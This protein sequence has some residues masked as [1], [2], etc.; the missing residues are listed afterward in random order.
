MNINEFMNLK[1]S[2]DLFW[3]DEDYAIT[4]LTIHSGRISKIVRQTITSKRVYLESHDNLSLCF[5]D[6]E[7]SYRLFVTYFEAV[8]FIRCK[9]NAAYEEA[10][11]ERRNAIKD[12]QYINNKIMHLTYTK[13][14][15]NKIYKMND[16]K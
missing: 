5:F 4:P 9:L 11:N 1:P 15:F 12:L 6:A 10:I 14:E 3:I 2:T 8:E 13:R 7:D 16:I